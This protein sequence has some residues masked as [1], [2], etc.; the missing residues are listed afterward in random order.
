MVNFDQT[1]GYRGCDSRAEDTIDI[2]EVVVHDRPPAAMRGHRN[3]SILGY[4]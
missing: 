1:F 2:I 3:W 4:L